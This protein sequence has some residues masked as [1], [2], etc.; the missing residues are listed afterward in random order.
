MDVLI[1]YNIRI[2][3]SSH[4]FPVPLYK[5]VRHGKY[6]RPQGEIL[7]W[8]TS[9]PCFPSYFFWVSSYT[10]DFRPSEMAFPFRFSAYPSRF[11]S[12][13]KTEHAAEYYII[14]RIAH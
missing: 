13:S 6:F 9:I 2:W 12:L 14:T 1:I 3:T 4:D 10:P 8:V 5:G 7:A 11:C